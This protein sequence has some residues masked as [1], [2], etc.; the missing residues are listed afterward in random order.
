MH[1]HWRLSH[2]RGYIALGRLDDAAA[3][4]ATLSP[5]LQD[6]EEALTLRAALLQAQE[7]WTELTVITSELRQRKPGDAGWW[8]MHAYATR[9]AGSLVEAEAILRDA[10]LHH[11]R[12][13]TIQFNLGCYAC[14]RGDLSLARDRVARAIAL[15]K[16]FAEHAADDPDLAALREAK[17]G[18]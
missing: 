17:A 8:V 12:D 14:L 2:A 9:R 1:P 5:E 4:L 7:R 18:A 6:G 15:D 3:E 13:A 11:P 10:E 16:T